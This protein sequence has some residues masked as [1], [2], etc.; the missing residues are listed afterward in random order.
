MELPR[1][2]LLRQTRPGRHSLRRWR[3]S[4]CD[5]LQVEVEVAGQQQDHQDDED[6]GGWREASGPVPAVTPATA[7]QRYHQQDN[8]E[9]GKH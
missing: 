3:R 1:G 6:D 9:D 7:G 5:V 8:Q 2:L 4:D